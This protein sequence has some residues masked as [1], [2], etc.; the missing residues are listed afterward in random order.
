[1]RKK[2]FGSRR[3]SEKPQKRQSANRPDY[4]DRIPRQVLFSVQGST[5]WRRRRDISTHKGTGMKEDNFKDQHD[6]F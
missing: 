4:V 5:G 2:A 3:I 6:K 1:M